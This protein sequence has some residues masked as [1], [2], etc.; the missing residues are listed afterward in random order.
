MFSAVECFDTRDSYRCGPCPP[1]MTGD[2][3]RGSCVPYMSCADKPCFP[4]VSCIDT[5]I[6]PKCGSCPRGY[7]GDGTKDGCRFDLMI[8]TSF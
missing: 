7:R 4:G 6:G 1:G 5:L 3:S 2:G 8:I